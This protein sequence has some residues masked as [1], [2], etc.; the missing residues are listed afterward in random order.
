MPAVG[1]SSTLADEGLE[2]LRETARAHAVAVA[3]RDRLLG[4]ANQQLAYANRLVDDKREEVLA[5]GRA[6]AS[7]EAQLLETG[8]RLAAAQ[9]VLARIEQS[10]SWQMLQ[11]ARGVLYGLIGE[12]SRLGRSFSRLLQLVGRLLSRSGE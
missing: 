4:E 2:L 10:V 1:R 11:R 9:A 8:D 5:V 12:S 6:L 3:E 7:V